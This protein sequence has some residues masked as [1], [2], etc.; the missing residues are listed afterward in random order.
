MW[1]ICGLRSGWILPTLHEWIR[2]DNYPFYPLSI[3]T[4][5]KKKGQ[6]GSGLSGIVE[7]YPLYPQAYNNIKELPLIQSF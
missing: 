5:R 3:H 1:I 2:G 7:G 4:D 6:T